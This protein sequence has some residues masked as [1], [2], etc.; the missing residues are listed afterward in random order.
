[1]E[2][3][4]ILSLLDSDGCN[5]QRQE[6]TEERWFN[7][8]WPEKDTPKPIAIIKLNIKLN[9]TALTFPYSLLRSYTLSNL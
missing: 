8:F 6:I 9:F 5:L 2:A 7:Y 3:S 1:M 4:Q